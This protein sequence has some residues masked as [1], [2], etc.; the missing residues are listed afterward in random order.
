MS[1]API[2]RVRDHTRYFSSEVKKHSLLADLVWVFL[3][4]YYFFVLCGVCHSEV[5]STTHRHVHGA[6]THPVHL[7]SGVRP[8]QPRALGCVCTTSPPN[9]L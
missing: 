3:S 1:L 4:D 7:I 9:Q 6:S 8:K 5:G 2:G